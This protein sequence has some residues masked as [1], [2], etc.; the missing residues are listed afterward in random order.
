[1]VRVMHATTRVDMSAEAYWA[2][3][4]D[5]GFDLFCAELDKSTFEPIDR[6]S[7]DRDGKSF[8]FM[9][10]LLLYKENPVPK[11]LQHMMGARALLPALVRAP[12]PA[13]TTATATCAR[14]PRRCRAVRLQVQGAVVP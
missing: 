7:E 3:R 13:P 11:N 5:Q 6:R 4:L 10:C 14:A 9:E 2:L 12:A 1:M 8:E